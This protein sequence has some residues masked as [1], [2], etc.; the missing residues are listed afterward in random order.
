VNDVIEWPAFGR[1]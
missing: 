1:S